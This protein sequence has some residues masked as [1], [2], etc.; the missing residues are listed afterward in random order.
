MR[1]AG[2]ASL[3]LPPQM[4]DLRYKQIF[5]VQVMSTCIIIIIQCEEFRLCL[6][7]ATLAAC[8]S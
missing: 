7:E 5:T 2:D 1:R 4:E 6:T 8:A 3:R